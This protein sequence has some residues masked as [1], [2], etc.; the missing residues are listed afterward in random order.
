MVDEKRERLVVGCMT[1]TSLDGLDVA[2]VR[3][4]GTGLAMRAEIV[5]SGSRPLPDTNDSDAI[6]LHYLA[7]GGP[8]DTE[9][10]AKAAHWFSVFHAE[11]VEEV[12]AMVGLRRPDLVC[13]HGQ[14]VFHRPPLSWQLFN[15][16]PLARSSGAPVVFDLRGA[17]LAAGGQGA[18]ITPLADWVLFRR[19]EPVV[20]VN[21]GGFCNITRLPSANTP[22]ATAWIEA[23]DVCA[24]NQVLDGVARKV[25]GT[26]FDANGETAAAGR[27]HPEAVEQLIRILEGQSIAGRSLG[28]GDEAAEW[29][30]NWWERIGLDLARCAVEGVAR[31][32][33]GACHG[34][35][36]AVLAGGGVKNAALVSRLR[37]LHSAAVTTT[38]EMGIAPEYREAACMAVLGALCQDRVAI[39]LPQV[40][41]VPAPA[42]VA[43]CWVWP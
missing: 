39:T 35:G 2:L 15:P 43:G 16:W 3:V 19:A 10:I 23:K 29:I 4:R 40:T 7:D 13:V 32:I 33:A 30:G 1:G 20:V 12:L 6:I 34:G 14:T 5:S 31:T 18:P 25:M 27:V 11:V 42:P 8:C 17:D 38:D 24:S 9:Q 26:P 41:G 21:L 36:P 22:D 28:T 37:E